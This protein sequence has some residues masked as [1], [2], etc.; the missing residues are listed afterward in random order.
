M[1]LQ[2]SATAVRPARVRR[3]APTV[4][5]F[6]V[7]SV[8]AVLAPGAPAYAAAVTCHG[9]KATIVGTHS[10]DVIH[11]TAGRDVIDGQGG[12]DTIYGRG[13][14]D[15]VCGG[16]GADHLYG[17]TGRDGLYGGKDFLH[18]ADEDGM[19]RLGD[20]VNGGPGS[21]RLDAGADT[22]P[23]D[24]VVLDVI[25]WD[26]SAHGVH[27]DLRTRTTR[28][29]GVDTFTGD[30]R[31]IVRGSA[32]GDVIEGTDRH[33]RID[34]GAGPDVV[35]A[36]GGNDNVNVGTY[37]HPGRAAARVWG[38]AGDDRLT[39]TESHVRITGGP[40]DDWIEAGG[41]LSHLS[42]GPGNDY[43]AGGD[44]VIVGG[45]GDDDLSGLIGDTAQFDGGAGSDYIQIDSILEGHRQAA[46]TG[47]WNM[48][49]GD[50]TFTLGDTT[51]IPVTNMESAHLPG[52]GTAWTVTGTS[53]DDFVGGDANTSSPVDFRGLAGDDSFGG[54]DGADLFDGGPG[55]DHSYGMDDG[56]D[57]CISVETI[58]G[59]D[60]EHV[61]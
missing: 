61:S 26:G 28:G 22:R 56:D 34:T 60:C 9:V 1:Y 29:G 27:I 10:S 16:Y 20:T 58:D 8:V 48:T 39:A 53:G 13:G 50:L 54:T 30:G 38:G 2:H 4:L 5:A 51:R 3:A 55:D 35:R 19:E 49:T 59:N 31:F 37:P 24:L 6:T 14:N 45:A 41:S 32:H 12:N 57:T 23:A 47:T 36:R 15:L 42:G 18:S 17:G 7:A 43:L 25:S 40:G 44:N 21:D 46:S 11:G 33:D 52:W